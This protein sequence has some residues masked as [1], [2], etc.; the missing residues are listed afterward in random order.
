MVVV[1]IFDKP[2]VY[3][4]IETSGGS[5]GSSRITEIAAV[6]IENGQETGAFHSLI[7]PGHALPYFITKITGLTDSDLADAPYFD[8]IAYELYQILDGAIFIAHNVRFDYSFIKHELKNAGFSYNPKL[9]CTVRLSRALYPEHNGHSLEKII[10]RHNIQVAGRHRAMDDTRAMMNFVSLAYTQ[11]GRELF[12]GAVNQQFKNRSLPPKLEVS[13]VNNIKNKPGVYVF[14]DEGGRPIYVGKSKQVRNRV[15]SH[16]SNDIRDSKE[17]RI[18]QAVR[19]IKTIETKN[20]LEALLLESRLVKE[21]LPI[22]NRQLRRSSANYLIMKST[23]SNGYDEL[24]IVQKD[25]SEVGDMSDVY[26]LF[27]SKSRAKNILQTWQKTFDLCPKLTGTEKTQKNCFLYQLGKCRGACLNLEESVKYNLRVTLA[28]QRTRM[29]NW[30][31][32]HPVVISASD[33]TNVV[34]DKWVVLGYLDNE[35]GSFNMVD[36]VFDLDSYK[37]LTSFIKRNLANISI[38]PFTMP[39]Y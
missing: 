32:D 23:N 13:A 8:E 22:Q 19:N 33:G 12:L 4:D 6:R 2:V 30:K 25:I 39:E 15:R 10:A 24:S 18:S 28:A 35:D 37:I 21:L 9:L 3:V 34:V 14:E 31:Y 38:K 7:N 17:M 16:F 11:K 5:V 27:T 1:D 26:G 36:K 20:E 29:E